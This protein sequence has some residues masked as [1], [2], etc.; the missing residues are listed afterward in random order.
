MH[1]DTHH[2]LYL[3]KDIYS[4]S[5]TEQSHQVVTVVFYTCVTVLDGAHPLISTQRWMIPVTEELNQFMWKELGAITS[6]HFSQSS[7]TFL[8]ITMSWYV[9][10]TYRLWHNVETV[11]S[12]FPWELQHFLLTTVGTTKTKTPFISIVLARELKSRSHL[13]NMHD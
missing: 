7:A 6:L 12:A 5:V 1:D 10:L 11:C 2:I 13:K 9:W 3:Y 4:A 8:L